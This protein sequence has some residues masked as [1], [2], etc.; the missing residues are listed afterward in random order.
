MNSRNIIVQ[1]RFEIPVVLDYE[2]PTFSLELPG[3][4]AIG[5]EISPS[6]KNFAPFLNALY[7]SL[8]DMIY[9]GEYDF[10]YVRAVTYENGNVILSLGLKPTNCTVVF[11]DNDDL[12]LFSLPYRPVEG[13]VICSMWEVEMVCYLGCEV[14]SIVGNYVGDEEGD[15]DG[16]EDYSDMPTQDMETEEHRSHGEHHRGDSVK[17]PVF[18]NKNKKLPN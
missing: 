15:E 6:D 12:Y 17:G 7:A 8:D 13:D 18:N 5:E 3:I 10:N 2:S 11:L 1:A 9:G 4:P 16:D 14:Y